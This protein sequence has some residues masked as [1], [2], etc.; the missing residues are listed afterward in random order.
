MTSQQTFAAFEHGTLY[1]ED[2]K[3]DLSTLPWCERFE[4]V[5]LKHL[6]TAKYTDGNF[7]YHLVRIA[8]EKKIG[9]HTHDTQ[10]ET[11]EVIHGQG[12]CLTQGKMLTY[13]PGV[14]SVLPKGVAHEVQA[15]ATGLFLF[16]KFFPALC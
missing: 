16:A 12:S 15:S 8:P 7:S 4:G 13:T 10:L 5:A 1:L 11:H 6:I 14:I 2:Q 3:I 9:L